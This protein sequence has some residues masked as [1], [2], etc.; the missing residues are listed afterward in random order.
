MIT[1]RK[2]AIDRV[3]EIVSE[4]VQTNNNICLCDILCEIKDTEDVETLVEL[5]TYIVGMLDNEI[6]Y[7]L[8]EN[9]K[10]L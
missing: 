3:N 6:V 4:K 5:K 9:I 10:T 8:K 2:D 1:C 7:R